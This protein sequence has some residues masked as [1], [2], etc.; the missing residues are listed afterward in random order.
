MTTKLKPVN[1][2]YAKNKPMFCTLETAEHTRFGL[3]IPSQQ[4]D[5][6]WHYVRDLRH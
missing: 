3:V 2:I 5:V 1:V 4:S 6:E